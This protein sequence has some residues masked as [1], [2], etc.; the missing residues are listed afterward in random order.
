[1]NATADW[2]SDHFPRAHAPAWPLGVL[3]GVATVA[4]YAR[5]FCFPM[6][7]QD[8]FQILS[9]SW[10]WERT[11]AG[12]WVPNNEHA[13]PLG[14][15]L[16]WAVVRAAGRPTAVP[17]A[18]ALVG[19][20]AL[21]LGMALVY[22]FVARELG[23]PFYRVIAVSL[24][25]VSAVYQQAV[26]W[27]AASFSV[28]A[29]DTLLLALLAAQSWR[30][31]GRALALDGAVLL[32]ALAP[33]WFASGVLAGPLC[34]LYLLSTDRESVRRFSL[35]PLL[36]TGLFLAVSL[37][38]TAEAILHLEH[39][40]GRT[41]VEAFQPVT[42]AAF[43]C[44]SLID[45][46]LLGAVG[47][48]TVEVPVPVVAV[49]LAGLAGAV[50]WWW[51]G[52]PERRLLPLGLGLVLGSYLLTY[53]ARATWGYEGVM[54]ETSW[55]RY[56]LLPQLGLALLVVGG[57]RGRQG[58]WFEL[59]PGGRLTARQ[60]RGTA[61]LIGA[62]LALQL[63][64][65][66]I[67][68]YSSDPRQAAVL[69]RVEVVDARCRQYRIG[70]DQARAALPRLDL[71]GWASEVNGWEFLRG[72]DAPQKLPADEVRALLEREAAPGR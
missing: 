36:G 47:V 7:I 15:L 1:M 40:R 4:L 21:L 43:T 42:A 26:Y 14:R 37:P 66:L 60:A 18:A 19:P 28:L 11:V 9:T 39:Y 30:Q 68:Y 22:R 45:N 31:T 71:G 51:R 12:L 5:C 17:L 72:S 3:A 54:T 64:R 59:D 58:R 24:F 53:S 29:L 20:A 63:P 33:A 56:H 67:G 13:M 2:P 55:S 62:L 38:R 16:T 41:A 70:A 25:G 65:G 6:L 34:C 44:R 32:S 61:V 10:T 69:R 48:W 8:D 46:L 27:F 50:G 23:H 52:T 57:L 49:A 35:L